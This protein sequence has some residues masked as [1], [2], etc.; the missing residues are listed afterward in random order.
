MTFQSINP[1]SSSLSSRLPLLRAYLTSHIYSDDLSLI[2]LYHVHARSKFSKFSP[3]QTPLPFKI[4]PHGASTHVPRMRS[5]IL[6]G[7]KY[8][9]KR[10]NENRV[11][12]R[13]RGSYCLY[14]LADLLLL[15]FATTIESRKSCQLK[16]EPH[17]KHVLPSCH[18]KTSRFGCRSQ[19][20]LQ[21]VS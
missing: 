12:R 20:C 7:D 10:L 13:S 9:A 3:S 14:S 2:D 6:C 11:I 18:T 15:P 4:Q 1:R 19:P 8:L 17:S 21:C 5:L 16:V